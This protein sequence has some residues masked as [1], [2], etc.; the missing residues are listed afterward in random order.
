[1]FGAIAGDI[2]GSVY[3]RHN[4]CRYDFELFT[5]HSTFTDDT[6]LTVAVMDHILRESD[7]AE[8]LR[9]W[10]HK[11]PT[12]GYGPGF[13]AWVGGHAQGDSRGNGAAM[14][15]SPFA[16]WWKK[17][18]EI[19]QRADDQARLTHDSEDGRKAAK[20]TALA[21]HNARY[22]LI[23]PCMLRA[24]NHYYALTVDWPPTTRKPG[25]L[26]RESVPAAL[27]AA[28]AS[29]SFEDAVRKA[30]SLGGDSD[31]VASIAGAVA[32]AWHGGVT[33]GVPNEIVQE[34]RKRLPA[35]MLK[36]VDEF[37]SKIDPSRFKDGHP[38]K[39]GTILFGIKPPKEW[40]ER[41]KAKRN[42]G[43]AASL[44]ENDYA[45]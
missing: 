9:E 34:V 22:G 43:Q 42:E 15:V 13:L 12:A 23:R 44:K 14:R 45:E 29:E 24:L 39:G 41:Q 11:Y 16:W 1:M 38:F 35:E 17:P 40:V 32:E 19:L 30:V 26:A 28:L 27:S 3:E 10:C 21:I 33:K 37:H 8:T 5:E 20:A 18:E 25:A 7:L 6:V 2:I 36:V 4:T 31:T